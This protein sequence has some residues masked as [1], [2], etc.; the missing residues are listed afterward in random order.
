MGKN[1]SRREALAVAASGLA[2]AALMAGPFARMAA[3]QTQK[4][5]VFVFRGKT[6]ILGPDGKGHDAFVPP[7]FVVKAG[8]PVTVDFINYDEGA[9][10][11][12]APKAKL[13]IQIKGGKEV[14]DDVQ[15]VTTTATFTIAQKGTYRWYCALTCDAGGHGWAMEQGYAGPGKEGYMAG[16]IVAM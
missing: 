4:I 6:G 14:G 3:A 9:H 12:T 15:P 1:V 10:T 5:T 11:L 8:A 16:F 7:N 2:G 13:N